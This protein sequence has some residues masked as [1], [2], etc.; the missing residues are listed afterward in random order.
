LRTGKAEKKGVEKLEWETMAEELM[1]L[2]EIFRGRRGN[3]GWLA[4]ILATRR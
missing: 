4:A 1:R 2:R 3:K